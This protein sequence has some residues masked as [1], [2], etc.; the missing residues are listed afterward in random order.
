MMSRFTGKVLAL[1]TSVAVASLIVSPAMAQDTA[2]QAG[3]AAAVRGAVTLVAV[4]LPQPSRVVGQTLGSGDKIFLGDNIETGPDSGMQIMLLDET[5]FTIGPSAGMVIDE[6][7]YDPATS[8]GQV[9][10]SIVKGAFRFVSGR[11]AKDRPQNMSVRTPV[12]T[13]GIRGTSAAGRVD[14]PDSDGNV[15]AS[16]VLL[17]PG[18]ENNANE[19][20][21]RI[22]VSN[23]GTSVEIT[24]SGFGTTIGGVNEPPTPPIRFEPGQIA[25]LTG[26][27][28]TDGG[29]RPATNGPSQNGGNNPDQGGNNPPN[30]N[31]NSNGGQGQNGSDNAGPAPRGSAAGRSPATAR[32]AVGGAPIGTGQANALSGQ[33][34]GGSAADIKLVGQIGGTVAKNN[35]ELIGALEASESTINTTVATFDQLRSIQKGTATFTVTNVPLEHI[36]GP[37]TNSGGSYNASLTLNFGTRNLTFNASSSN[38]FFNGGAVQSF[39]HSSGVGP[40]SS[41]SYATEKGFVKGSDNSIDNPGSFTTA[42]TDGATVTAGGAVLNNVDAGV[43]AAQ[44]FFEITI[45]NGTNVIAGKRTVGRQ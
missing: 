43:I 24:R 9:T 29:A 44:G 30:G 39:V 2:G 36:K 35:Q 32:P 33:N 8:T 11:V 13:I 31:A 41:T 15:G 12:G 37:H 34:V 21:G 42:P 28:G 5:I 22:T 14:P 4:A 20:A 19:R 10:A 38:Y 45:D 26:A 17:G 18:P 40:G 3:V 25:S 6:F 1:S 23:G 27:L 16:I 7:V